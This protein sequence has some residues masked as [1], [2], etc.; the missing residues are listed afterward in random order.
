MVIGVPEFHVVIEVRGVQKKMKHV[1]CLKWEYNF[2]FAS[3]VCHL[4]ITYVK[5][6]EDS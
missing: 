6:A 2:H 3:F 1:I 4:T 5:V